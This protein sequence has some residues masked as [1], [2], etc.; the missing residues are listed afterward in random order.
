MSRHIP[1]A[2]ETAN[3]AQKAV[4]DAIKNGPRGHVRGPFP[5]LLHSPGVA[6]HVQK[7]GGY[8]RFDSRMPDK[9][10]ELAV[11]VTSRFWHAEF[12]W[13]AH[14]PLAEKFGISPQAIETIRTG[15]HP[16]FADRAEQ[17]VYDFMR[18]LHEKH[19]V[20]DE[21]YRNAQQILG[22]EVVTDLIGMAGYYTLLAMVLNVYEV[23]LPDGSKP[24]PD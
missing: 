2:P 22:Q 7:L 23:P 8:I 12:E 24:F 5:V 13:F 9:L 10:R 17:T 4:Y 16:M 1:V 14:A 19:N 20:G 21:T 3:P 15:G 11:L 18:D 6:D